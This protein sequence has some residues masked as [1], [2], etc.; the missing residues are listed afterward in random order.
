MRITSVYLDTDANHYTPE[1]CREIPSLKTFSFLKIPSFS[2][3][4][5]TSRPKSMIN[6]DAHYYQNHVEAYPYTLGV[7][8]YKDL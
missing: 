2:K 8:I 3:S 7:P 1:K 5:G 6:M 4:R